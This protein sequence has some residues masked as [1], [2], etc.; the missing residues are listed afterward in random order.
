MK[1]QITVLLV[2]MAGLAFAAPSGAA[3]GAFSFPSSATE[4]DNDALRKLTVVIEQFLPPLIKAISDNNGDIVTRINKV[5]DSSL[6][7]GRETVLVQNPDPNQEILKEIDAAR[8][9]TPLI[10]QVVRSMQRVIQNAGNNFD[11]TDLTPFNQ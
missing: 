8:E 10:M 3:T 7:L 5:V 6:A 9:S 11:S 1:L 2:S 4:I